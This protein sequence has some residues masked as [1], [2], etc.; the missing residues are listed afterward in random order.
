[1]GAWKTLR[2]WK[3][4]GEDTLDDTDGEMTLSPSMS[5]IQLLYDFTFFFSLLVIV[6]Q[7]L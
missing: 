1:M 5:C 7:F 6:F 3:N 4:D 2:A